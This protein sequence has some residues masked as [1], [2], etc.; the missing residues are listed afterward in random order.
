LPEQHAAQ[1]ALQAVPE[2]RA[3]RAAPQALAAQQP[4]AAAWDEVQPPG[5]EP[6]FPPLAGQVPEQARCRELA[7]HWVALPVAS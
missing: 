1:A 6:A 4:D 5:V 3:A 7:L 2:Q